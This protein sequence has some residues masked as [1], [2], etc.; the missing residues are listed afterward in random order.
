MNGS[1]NK[2]LQTQKFK[3]KFFK[4][5]KMIKIKVL[6]TT[7]VIC[8]GLELKNFLEGFRASSY[9]STLIF[10][11]FGTNLIPNFISAAYIDS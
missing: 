7:Y 3:V 11:Y 4:Y 8:S 10:C 1:C 6:V 9:A 5:I 2:G